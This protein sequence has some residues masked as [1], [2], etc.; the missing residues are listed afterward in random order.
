MGA[1]E[2]V[3]QYGQAHDPWREGRSS[4]RHVDTLRC[5][6][7]WFVVAITSAPRYFMLMFLGKLSFKM[8]SRGKFAWDYVSGA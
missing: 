8:F 2:W 4:M 3:D 5:D 1:G 6:E 7:V